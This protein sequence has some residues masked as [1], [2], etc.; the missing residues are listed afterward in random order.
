M[1]TS[2]DNKRLTQVGPG[3]PLGNFFRRYWIPAAVLEEIKEPGGAPVRVGLLGEKLVAFRDPDGEPGLMKEHCP[4]RGASLAYGRNESGGLRCLYHGWKMA[5]NGSISDMPPEPPESRMKDV[6]KHTAYPVQEAGGILWTYMGPAENMPPFP[7]FPWL[8]L[9]EGQLLVVK[10]F[11]DNNYL[12]GLEGDL[13]P[14]H[15]NYLHKDFDEEIA[16]QS[17]SGAGWKSISN[18]MSDGAPAIH[19]EETPQ[20]M[21]VGAVRK[22]DEPGVAYVR[23]TEWV[24]PFYTHIATGPNESQLFKAWLPIDDYS[25]FTF[26]IHYDTRKK[27]DVPAIYS[28]WGHR[29]QYPD[30]RTPHTL[31]NKHLQD[32]KMMVDGNFSGVSGAAVQDRAVQE[33]MGAI[34]DRTQE[35]LGTS[36]KAVIF[37][38]R[39]ILRKMREMQEGKPLP[40]TT[41]EANFNLRAA[42]VYMPV[43][44]PWQEA[45][46]WIEAQEAGLKEPA[47]MELKG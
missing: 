2:E 12:Q 38:R 11:Q 8:D 33:S 7:R 27:L 1:L 18:L 32:R 47:S 36:D 46:R 42:S 15:P 43:D 21:R 28:N 23:T 44:Q 31:E 25:C 4:H 10:M 30:Y 35:H 22:T 16:R 13:D 20:L 24:A 26:Y 6:L 14:A 41:D 40:A 5:H 45:V 29:T 19:V 39:L 34:F 17:W 9:P 37:Y 3:T